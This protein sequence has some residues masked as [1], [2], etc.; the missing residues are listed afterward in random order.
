MGPSTPVIRVE[1]T[2]FGHLLKR[3]GLTHKDRFRNCPFH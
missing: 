3:D 2:L 1:E